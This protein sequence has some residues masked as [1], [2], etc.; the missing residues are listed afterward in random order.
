M[1]TEALVLTAPTSKRTRERN[2]KARGVFEKIP[3]SG[4]WWIRYTDAQGRYRREKAG[5][6]GMAI[7][8]YRKRKTDALAG[9][10]LPEKLRRPTV[11]FA[12]IAR[13]ALAYS[14]ANKLSYRN[15]CTRMEKL[16]GWFREYPAEAITHADIERRFAG[17]PWSAATWNRYRA[18]LSLTYRLAI[19]NGKLKENPA[20]LVRHRLENNARTRFLSEK[21]ETALREVISEKC[22]ERIAELDLAL[23]TG[24]RLSEQY[25]LTWG[26][27]NLAL[28]ILTVPRS[29]N[30]ST[31][32]VPLNTAALAALEALRKGSNGSPLVCGGA[33]TSRQWFEPVVRT[34]GLQSFSW[35][36]LRH[37]FAS[38]L[39][40]AGVDI[41]TVQELLGHTTLAMTVRYSHLAPKHTLAAVERLAGFSERPTD[42]TTDTGHF[43]RPAA[44]VAILQ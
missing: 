27:V 36:C 40:M 24:L 7:E 13:D 5:M 26:N 38:R 21:E 35:H 28:R 32:H 4:V 2:A 6:K 18:M 34:A 29:K 31:R 43:E 19:R 16:L 42:T 15:D 37:T 44:Q 1:E 10:K 9:K 20:R 17:E 11:T 3:G 25:G 41:R 14:K 22:P 39:V 8:L 23:N 33:K 12:D 30:G